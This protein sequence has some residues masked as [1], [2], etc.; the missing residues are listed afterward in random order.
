MIIMDKDPFAMDPMEI[1]NI[2][3]LETIKD[4]DTVY[5]KE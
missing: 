5:T 3:I 1:K 4:G 2:E